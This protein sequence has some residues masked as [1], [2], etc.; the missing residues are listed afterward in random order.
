MHGEL[1]PRVMRNLNRNAKTVIIGALFLFFSVLIYMSLCTLPCEN[2][3]LREHM[4]QHKHGEPYDHVKNFAAAKKYN[5]FL[6]VLILCSPKA[7]NQRN[8]IRTTWLADVPSQILPYFVIGT[9]SLTTQEIST[10]EYEHS[11]YNDLL[12]L[13]DFVDSYYAL[14]GKVMEAF[15]WIDRHVAYEF[16]FKGDDDT[17]ARIDLIAQELSSMPSDRLYWGF[18][19]GRAHVKRSGKWEEKKWIIGDR[20]APHARGGGYVLSADL[21]HYIVKNSKYLQKFNS[22]DISVGAWL[23]PLDIERR[24]DPRFD[25]EYQSRGCH[26]DYIVTHKQSVNAMKE[27]S[28]NLQSSGQLCTKEFRTK[29]SYIYNWE[30]LPSQ[31]CKRLNS[32]SIP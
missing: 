21:V 13:E 26:N 14:T 20:Y 28:A 15:S 7:F 30:V 3:M 8:A 23:S 5:A 32:S 25:T 12:L 19:D 4:E 31:C 22:E 17:F 18:F 27:K 2:A 9:G 6:V 29:P 24:H 11:R 1:S 10:L 16:V